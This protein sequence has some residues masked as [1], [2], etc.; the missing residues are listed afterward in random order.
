MKLDRVQ[1]S[2]QWG[3]GVTVHR[4]QGVMVEEGE[5]QAREADMEVVVGIFLLAF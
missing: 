2:L 5:A 1:I 3:E 4:H